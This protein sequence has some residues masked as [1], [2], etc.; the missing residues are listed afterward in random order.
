MPLVMTTMRRLQ[1]VSK[2]VYRQQQTMCDGKTNRIDDRIVSLHQSHIR[3]IVR[4]KA[5]S[6]Y[7]F[8]LDDVFIC[9]LDKRG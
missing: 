4:G 9:I 7:E 8:V 2:E 1:C 3:C 6:P 5:G